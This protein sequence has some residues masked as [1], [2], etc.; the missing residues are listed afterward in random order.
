MQVQIHITVFLQVIFV[1][2]NTLRLSGNSKILLHTEQLHNF[3][4]FIYRIDKL[5]GLLYGLLYCYG[6]FVLWKPLSFI[7]I[8]WKRVATEFSGV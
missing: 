2:K 6:A 8:V 3:R 1:F 5:H 4:R 7:V